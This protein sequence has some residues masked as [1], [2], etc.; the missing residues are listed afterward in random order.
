LTTEEPLICQPQFKGEDQ[1]PK[2]PYQLPWPVWG[3]NTIFLVVGFVEW[4]CV[5]EWTNSSSACGCGP[6]RS[7]GHI[8]ATTPSWW[9]IVGK[10]SQ[11]W[12][13]FAWFMRYSAPP[14]QVHISLNPCTFIIL[15]CATPDDCFSCFFIPKISA[16]LKQD[17]SA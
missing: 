13:F 17:A 3:G 8:W 6:R 16:T 2:S 14:P 1:Q 12:E 9:Q 10:N 5:E 7:R 11:H 15:S 4:V